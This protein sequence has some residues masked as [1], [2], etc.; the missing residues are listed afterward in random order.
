MGAGGA[1]GG[2][3][4][5][6][7]RAVS[8][9]AI[10]EIVATRRFSDGAEFVG[11]IA[12][13]A[14]ALWAVVDARG[15]IWRREVSEIWRVPPSDPRL[16]AIAARAMPEVPHPEPVE[17]RPEPAEAREPPRLYAER[18]L[19]AIDEGY[20]TSVAIARRLGAEPQHVAERLNRL[21]AAGRI[22]RVGE[23]RRRGVPLLIWARADAGASP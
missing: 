15:V 17:R 23:Y 18:I 2:A 1:G 6:R 16:K 14:A 8:T 7:G 13:E 11:R 10:G 22:A 19:D 5:I 12:G 20:V 21:A 4:E 3:R 9:F